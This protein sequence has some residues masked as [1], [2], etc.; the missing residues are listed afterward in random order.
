M[1]RIS[2]KVLSTL[3]PAPRTDNSRSSS[4][5]RVPAGRERRGNGAGRCAADQK[6]IFGQY[7]RIRIRP[8]RLP[9]CPPPPQLEGGK[10]HVD[11]PLLRIDRDGISAAQQPDGTTDGGL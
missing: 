3:T 8:A 9:G 1:S 4:G 5:D 10:L 11:A 7:P 2:L 6:R